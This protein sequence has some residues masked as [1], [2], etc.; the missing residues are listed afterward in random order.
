MAIVDTRLMIGLVAVGILY[1]S[2]KLFLAANKNNRLYKDEL[3]KVVSSD[4]YKV[5]G[6]FE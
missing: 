1:L 2:F 3:D 5:K 4:E 6:R